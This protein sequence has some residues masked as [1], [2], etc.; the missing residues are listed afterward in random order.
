MAGTV[1]GTFQVL[2]FNIQFHSFPLIVEYQLLK[3]G[4]PLDPRTCLLNRFLYAGDCALFETDVSFSLKEV[5]GQRGDFP[6]DPTC[7]TVC[8]Q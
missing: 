6:F 3:L 4:K 8:S 7:F 5:G 1:T 2:E